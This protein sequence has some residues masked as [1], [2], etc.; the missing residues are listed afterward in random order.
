MNSID[1][2]D[3][4][5][6]TLN[7]NSC[8]VDFIDAKTLD[9]AIYG[10]SYSETEKLYRRMPKEVADAVS[11]GVSNLSYHTASGRIKIKTD[12]PFLMIRAEVPCNI[13]MNAMSVSGQWGFTIKDKNF[14]HGVI[15]PT[16]NDI[17]FQRDN[18]RTYFQGMRY[19]G[20]GEHDLTVYTPLCNGVFEIYFGIKKGCY[21][22]KGSDYTYKKPVVFYG[23]SIT[24]GAGATASAN[25]YINII[26]HTLDTDV[27]N[28]GFSG[29][30][31]G[32]QVMS[33]YLAR[34]DPS[35]YVIDYDHNAPDYVHLEK[36]HY[37]LYENIRSKHPDVPII[38]V[39]R[40]DVDRDTITVDG[41]SREPVI[42]FYPNGNYDVNRRLKVVKNTYL[43]AVAN[44]DKNVYFIPGN[45]L[46]PEDVR[47][48]ASADTCHP[49]DL[50]FYYMAKTIGG[51]LKI[52]LK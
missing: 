36:T 27:Y 48:Y 4:N 19:L 35:A 33:D 39:T 15:G 21:L 14:F 51:V 32:E 40:P 29:N 6:K 7:V 26:S 25:N 3:A 5:F 13:V 18:D 44:G 9:G 1:K 38:F 49:N 46:I 10:I 37:P 28:L 30:A 12:S 24:Q 17:F 50:G 41:V 20:E 47:P 45:E 52:L 22:T 34:L 2:F 16:D 43:K 11:E 42:G 23:S 31:K 8:D